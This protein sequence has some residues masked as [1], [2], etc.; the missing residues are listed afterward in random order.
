MKITYTDPQNWVVSPQKAPL[1]QILD[2]IGDDLNQGTRVM[3]RFFETL[4][5]KGILS[6]DDLGK[7][8]DINIT[9]IQP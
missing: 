8:L 4:H 9:E 7:I 5:A 6:Q 2:D 1:W 3:A